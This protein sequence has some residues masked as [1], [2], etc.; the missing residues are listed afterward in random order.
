MSEFLHERNTLNQVW[1]QMG[2]F[3]LEIES[4]QHNIYIIIYIFNN[5]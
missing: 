4:I 2:A 1:K 5:M 3:P